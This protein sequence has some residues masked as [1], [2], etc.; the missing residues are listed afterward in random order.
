MAQNGNVAVK[1]LLKRAF[2]G[3]PAHLRLRTAVS[4]TFSQ[5]K[6]KR[7]DGT[8]GKQRCVGRPLYAYVEFVYSKTHLKVSS[9]CSLGIPSQSSEGILRPND[10]FYDVCFRPVRLL[11]QLL[12]IKKRKENVFNVAFMAIGHET[13]G[14]AIFLVLIHFIFVCSFAVTQR[15]L[16][17]ETFLTRKLFS[18]ITL[19]NSSERK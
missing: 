9:G 14:N 13:D 7:K 11:V 18:N 6:K 4:R 10:M 12:K 5:V 17:A 16:A 15:A 2:Q 3:N 1:P 8:K 19:F